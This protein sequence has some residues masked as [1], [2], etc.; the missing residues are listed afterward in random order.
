MRIFQKL[1]NTDEK[2]QA[3]KIEFNLYFH[4]IS[5]YCG[6][7]IWSPMGVKKVVHVWWFISGS[8]GKLLP[9]IA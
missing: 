5:P 2:F 1:Y 4:T 7:H 9:C 8:V 3:I 6:D